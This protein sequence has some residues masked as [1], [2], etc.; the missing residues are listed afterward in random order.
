MVKETINMTIHNTVC[1][2]KLLMENIDRYQLIKCPIVGFYSETFNLVNG[3][4][5]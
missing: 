5:C 3:L 2:E 4:F 1:S